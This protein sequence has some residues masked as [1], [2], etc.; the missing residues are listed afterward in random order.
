MVSRH[1]Y[2]ALDGPLVI[3]FEQDGVAA[4]VDGGM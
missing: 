2:L 3:L 4:P 1:M